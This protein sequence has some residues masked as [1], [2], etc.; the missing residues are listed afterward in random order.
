MRF[1]AL[2]NFEEKETEFVSEAVELRKRFTLN[3]AESFVKLEGR[4]PGDAVPLSTEK[5]WEVVK[6]HK[7]LDLPAH[8]V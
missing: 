8:K 1:E 5:V 7:D 2:S 6:S 4:L 3:G